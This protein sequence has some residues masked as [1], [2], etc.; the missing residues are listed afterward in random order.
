MVTQKGRVRVELL[1]IKCAAPLLG[2]LNRRLPTIETAKDVAGEVWISATKGID[3]LRYPEAARSWLF[4]IAYNAVVNY[5]RTTKATTEVLE[6]DALSPWAL[7]PADSL[8]EPEAL[9][10]D[11]ARVGE[12]TQLV[13]TLPPLPQSIFLLMADGYNYK[14]IGNRLHLTQPAVRVLVHRLRRYL[15]Q[16]LQRQ[17]QGLTAATARM[18]LRVDP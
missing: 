16:G 17:R 3:N 4:R 14:D 7:H 1:Y 18:P 10:E 15:I 13:E 8:H 11:K 5:Y 12:I 2:Y 6:A 9:Y